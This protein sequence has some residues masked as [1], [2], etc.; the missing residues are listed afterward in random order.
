MRVPMH[1]VNILNYIIK[2]ES[3]LIQRSTTERGGLNQMSP[4]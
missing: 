3:L 1:I 4:I 2:N